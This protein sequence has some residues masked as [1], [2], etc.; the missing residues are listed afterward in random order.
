VLDCVEYCKWCCNHKVGALENYLKVD[1]LHLSTVHRHRVLNQVIVCG[2]QKTRYH[3]YDS[4]LNHIIATA[5]AILGNV[6][7]SR[8]QLCDNQACAACNVD[9]RY[10][11][12]KQ[13]L[14]PRNIKNNETRP[15]NCVVAQRNCVQSK[16][17]GNSFNRVKNAGTHRIQ[18]HVAI[19]S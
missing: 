13:V 9:T 12:F 3:Y 15:K 5:T 8:H 10:W 2:I 18:Q 7:R 19:F 11:F 17:Y 14:E 16:K 1:V 4:I 6:L